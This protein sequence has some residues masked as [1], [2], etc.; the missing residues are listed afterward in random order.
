MFTIPDILN[1]ITYYNQKEMY[2]IL[3]KSV[4]ET[5]IELS[6]DKK[7]LGAQIGFTTILHTWGQNL[8]QHPHLHCIV[9]AGGIDELGRW[10]SSKKKFFL[11]VKVLSRKFRGKFLY[12]LK[13]SKLELKGE[14]EYLKEPYNYDKLLS[15][16]YR[17]EWIVYCKPPFKTV[18]NVVEYLGRYTHRIAISNSRILDTQ[19][20]IV[21][22]KWRDYKDKNK[23][24]VMKLTS[25]EFMRRF[26]THILPPRFMKIR[27]YG[28][29]GN[30][31]KNTK[32][33]LCKKLTNTKILIKEKISPL[34]LLKQVTGK[35]LNLCPVCNKGH[36]HIPVPT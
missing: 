5:L 9:P 32:L 24:K 10:K 3:F 21:T 4:S 6:K 25:D 15:D 8:M 26:I 11:P 30:R 22:F 34:E 27:Y 33:E 19:N 2:N 18:N 12:Y 17:K 7:Y 36:L 35:D 14:I 16:L 23:W 31:N 13:Q 1:P 29:L 20:N 28:L